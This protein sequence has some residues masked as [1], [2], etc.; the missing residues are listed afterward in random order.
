MPYLLALILLLTAVSAQAAGIDGLAFVPSRL[1]SEVAVIDTRSGGVVRRLPTGSPPLHAAVSD[2][3]R[4][5]VT[6]SWRGDTV[7]LIDPDGILPTERIAIGVRPDGIELDASGKLLAV[8]SLESD[9]VSLV[10]LEARRELAV[11]EGFASPH[12][13]T[14]A[15]DGRR[16]YVSNLAAN[17]VSVVDVAARTTAEPIVL[18]PPEADLGGIGNL[19]VTADGKRLLA[20]VGDGDRLAVVDLPGGR[21]RDWVRVGELPWRAFPTM[22]GRRI[23]VPSN[24]DGTA[25]VLDGET[26]RELGRVPVGGDISSVNTARFETVGLVFS[27]DARKAT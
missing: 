25:S 9:K 4:R 1:A 11:L 8:S 6:T 17:Y 13:L 21:V 19:T 2:S 24:G 3:L 10:D 18:G 16:L 20:T 26:M 7:N 14:F 5:V 27:R 15:P 12:H 23:I 22:D